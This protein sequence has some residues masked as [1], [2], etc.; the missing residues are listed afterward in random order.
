MANLVLLLDRIGSHAPLPS[1][2]IVAI[3][4]STQTGGVFDD[5][6]YSGNRRR[7]VD[8][9]NDSWWDA[10]AE[11]GWCYLHSSAAGRRA[12]SSLG[13]TTTDPIL[14]PVE[15]AD[16]VAR[17][18]QRVKL[19][20]KD[21]LEE[22]ERIVLIGGSQL[23]VAQDLDHGVSWAHDVSVC[24][25]KPWYRYVTHK[26]VSASGWTQALQTMMDDFEDQMIEKG[27]LWFFHNANQ[28]E[29][30]TT[31]GRMGLDVYKVKDNGDR[32]TNHVFPGTYPAGQDVLTWDMHASVEDL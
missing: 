13:F 24:W 16:Y 9:E 20:F 15:P 23:S 29:W 7:A 27:L 31:G 22:A 18:K 1:G 6:D 5:G 26:L 28:S 21:N 25:W 19:A 32:P 4:T 17:W 11:P 14:V 12:A 2:K 8:T 10:N 3:G 30:R